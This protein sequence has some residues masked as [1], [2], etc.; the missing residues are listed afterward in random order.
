MIK[1]FKIFESN[2]KL[3]KGNYV[4]CKELTN[5][6]DEDEK[7]AQEFIESN[8]GQYI[9]FDRT[10]DNKFGIK[11]ENV[12]SQLED[13]FFDIQDGIDGIRWMMRDEIIHYS[14]NKEDLEVLFDVKKYNL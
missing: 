5:G 7:A 3:K 1:N 4:I 8:V 11:Y 6:Y 2:T 9:M 12:P 14:K 10:A 13:H